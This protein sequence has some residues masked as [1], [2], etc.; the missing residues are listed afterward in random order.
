M[1]ETAEDYFFSSI[2]KQWWGFISIWKLVYGGRK[3]PDYCISWSTCLDETEL[4]GLYIPCRV[5]GMI[6]LTSALASSVRFL[7]SSTSREPGLC[8]PGFTTTLSNTPAKPRH[9]RQLLACSTANI[10]KEKRKKVVSNERNVSTVRVWVCI[11]YELWIFD[12]GW[13]KESISL[14][15]IFRLCHLC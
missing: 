9:G 1:T 12:A 11:D 6:V 13:I 10:L 14:H 8:A 7:A 5:M 15:P 3:E 2:A 4:H